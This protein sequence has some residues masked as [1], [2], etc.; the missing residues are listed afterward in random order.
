LGNAVTHGTAARPIRVR[1]TTQGGEFELSVANSGEPI[2]LAAMD[3][4]FQP[5]YRLAGPDSS[6]G[7]GLG[8]YIASEIAHAHR[9]RIDVTSSPEET[10][11][12]FLMPI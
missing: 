4:L 10:R 5:F 11:F 2:P 7:L 9:G 6:Q 3:Q 8:L 12:T 1:A